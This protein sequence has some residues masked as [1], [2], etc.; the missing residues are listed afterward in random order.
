[1]GLFGSL[2]KI[3]GGDSS[4][5]SNVPQGS[6]QQQ[7]GDIFSLLFTSPQ[8]M[9]ALQM[10]SAI[11]QNPWDYLSQFETS[12]GSGPGFLQLPGG[13]KIDMGKLAQAN[14]ALSDQYETK[15]LQFFEDFVGKLEKVPALADMVAKSKGQNLLTPA[16]TAAFEGLGGAALGSAASGGFL[17]DPLKQQNVLGPVAYQKAMTE[18]G[19]QQD[20][21]NTLLGLAG[22]GGIPTFSQNSLFAAGP[23]QWSSAA[24]GA[25]GLFGMQNLQNQF[26]AASLNTQL[27]QG[28]D[29]FNLGIMHDAGKSVL[30]F[31]GGFM[32]GGGK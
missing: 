23:S 14:V 20:A 5:I 32:G 18:F 8:I 21:Q 7:W 10:S 1:M 3:L 16:M 19:I 11:G 28:M 15:Q 6:V 24:G 27:K 17:A 2:S 26:N 12:T 9:Q 4:K 13:G 22:V 30:D 31:F 29:Q 25:A